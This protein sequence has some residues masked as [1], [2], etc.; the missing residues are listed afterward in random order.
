[1]NLCSAFRA[2]VF[3]VMPTASLTHSD[4]NTTTSPACSSNS[5]HRSMVS[6]RGEREREREV[7]EVGGGGEG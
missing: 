7:M 2:S 3:V 4:L 6:V 1:M 5:L